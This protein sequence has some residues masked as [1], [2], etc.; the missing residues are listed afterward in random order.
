MHTPKVIPGCSA[1][2]DL[3]QRPPGDK[4]QS[5][6]HQVASGYVALHRPDLSHSDASNL[7]RR[8]ATVAWE[9]V[10]GGQLYSRKYIVLCIYDIVQTRPFN[11]DKF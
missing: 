10:L 3:L 1:L 5:T 9:G 8:A 4:L 7:A 11:Y 2:Y 6:I